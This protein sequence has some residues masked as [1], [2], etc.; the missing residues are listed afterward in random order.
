MAYDAERERVLVHGGSVLIGIQN[1]AGQYQDGSAVWYEETYA[2][3]GTEFKALPSAGPGSRAHHCLAYD[4][5]RKLTVLIGGV[6]KERVRPSE[7]WGWDGSQ[8]RKLAEG[9]PAPRGRARMA[10]HEPTGEMVLY[11]GDVPHSG[12]GFKVAEDTWTFDGSKWTERKPKTSPGPRFMHA[13]A[14]WPH[15]KKVVLYGGAQGPAE[16]DDAWAWD[17]ENW[18]KM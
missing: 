18:S 11:G 4:P 2:F 17:G 1:S 5:I 12:R 3:D 6:N 7:T 8:W 15:A 13:M 14:Y 9:G 16:R 10:F